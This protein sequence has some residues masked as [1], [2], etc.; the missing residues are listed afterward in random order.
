MTRY[1]VKK[2]ARLENTFTTNQ[3]RVHNFSNVAMKKK[4]YTFKR[5]L[6]HYPHMNLFFLVAALKNSQKELFYWVT[7][8][9]DE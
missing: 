1:C 5:I 4:R 7:K 2:L 6:K 9:I 3:N 8:T